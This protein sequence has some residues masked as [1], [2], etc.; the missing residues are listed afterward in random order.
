MNSLFRTDNVILSNVLQK[1]VIIIHLILPKL[2][3]CSIPPRKLRYIVYPYVELWQGEKSLLCSIASL[4]HCLFNACPFR[5]Y[6]KS[7]NLNS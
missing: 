7:A 1:S 6:F 2:H 5:L 3:E 4:I